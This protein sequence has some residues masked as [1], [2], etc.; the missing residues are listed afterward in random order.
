SV[1]DRHDILRTG[2][3]WDG[4]RE[5]VQVVVRRAEVPVD[6]VDLGCVDG[7]LTQGL[8]DLC[9]PSLDIRQAP[10]LRATVAA[11]PGSD[12]W[13]L[14]LQAHHLVQDHTALAVLLGEVRAL[15]DGDAG[16]LPVPV[17]FREFVAQARLGVSRAEHERFFGELLGGVS[18]PTAPFGLLDVHGDGSD[19]AEATAVLDTGLAARLRE[20]AR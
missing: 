11:E 9:S 13:L 3:A 2:F 10:L 12:R 5:P 16:A 4:L 14:A 19:V 7:D 20:Q 17:P 15:L 6:E 8:L 1:V 18:E